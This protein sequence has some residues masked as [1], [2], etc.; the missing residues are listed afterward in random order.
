MDK[1]A[2]DESGREWSHFNGTQHY[3]YTFCGETLLSL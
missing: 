3:E 1:L 2:K